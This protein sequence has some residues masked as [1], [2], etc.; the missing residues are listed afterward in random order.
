MVIYKAELK[1]LARYIL[2]WSVVLGVCI[3]LFYPIY[4]GF[5]LSGITLPDEFFADDHFMN[6]LGINM[7]YLLTPLGVYAFLNSFVML[8]S[9]INATY[10]GIRIFTSEYLQK[11]ADFLFSKP[12][13]RSKI[14]RA[15]F[16]AAFCGIGIISVA[17]IFA[18]FFIVLATK[19]D[20]FVLSTFLL[21]SL[22]VFFI[23]V[24]FLSL[25][26]LIGSLFPRMRTPI[27]TSSGVA[28]LLYILGS[29]SRKIHNDFIKAFSP[30]TYFDM[31][32]IFS[33][34]FYKPLNVFLFFVGTF[35]FI[36]LAYRIFSKK[37]VILTV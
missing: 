30:F 7:K 22:S 35:V 6:T 29:F 13:P 9:A 21:F 17:Y 8:A 4:T 3:V 36:F 28:F 34:G 20:A 19:A 37:D 31:G 5:I 11:T 14:F 10:L 25:G 12:F 2:L 16:A 15:K 18:S 23:Q 27:M 24:I 26:A 33:N 1:L 32:D